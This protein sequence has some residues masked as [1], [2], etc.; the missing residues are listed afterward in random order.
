MKEVSKCIYAPVFGDRQTCCKNMF[1]F[2]QVHFCN[3]RSVLL[4]VSCRQVSVP[5]SHHWIMME[6]FF[7][8]FSYLSHSALQTRPHERPGTDITH[9]TSHV[10]I[11]RTAHVTSDSDTRLSCS[12]HGTHGAGT[13]K[14]GHRAPRSRDDKTQTGS[15]ETIRMSAD[16]ITG[17]CVSQFSDFKTKIINIYQKF[18]RKR[19]QR[20]DQLSNQ[21]ENYYST[22]C[23][24]AMEL[25]MRILRSQFQ[26]PSSV[27]RTTVSL[28]LGLLAWAK[29]ERAGDSWC[30]IIFRRERERETIIR[31]SL[32]TVVT[33]DPGHHE[34]GHATG[35]GNPQSTIPSW[36]S[37]T[38]PTRPRSVA[39]PSNS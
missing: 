26:L 15:F 30:W 11:G 4:S 28:P 18:F 7:C 22:V 19:T 32:V 36:H 23:G 39:T 25:W 29:S 37:D 10:N 27:E 38:A 20:I 2:V 24:W 16:D 14:V 9:H 21:F 5:G 35:G 8:S 12:A 31:W 13:E 1:C 6:E 33:T 17:M 3:Q 34:P